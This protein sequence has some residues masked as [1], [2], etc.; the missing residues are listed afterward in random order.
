MF[1]FNTKPKIRTRRI[2]TR[3]ANDTIAW[4]ALVTSIRATYL[5]RIQSKVI[6]LL[7]YSLLKCVTVLYLAIK[8]APFNKYIV[9]EFFVD[10]C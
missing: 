3:D 8:N 2:L 10:H 5:R 4:L 7:H 6:P 9:E 1:F